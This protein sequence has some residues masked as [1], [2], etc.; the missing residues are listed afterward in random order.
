MPYVVNAH[1]I[2]AEYNRSFC[3]DPRSKL[4]RAKSL[5]KTFRNHEKPMTSSTLY[6]K[7]LAG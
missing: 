6:P 1:N 3:N 5:L 4:G 7:G 2:T